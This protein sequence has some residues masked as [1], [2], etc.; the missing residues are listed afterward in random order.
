MA[1][2]LLSSY[3]IQK[4]NQFTKKINII[5]FSLLL[6]ISLIL[7]FIYYT[8]HLYSQ[9]DDASIK[10]QTLESELKSAKNTAPVIAVNAKTDPPGIISLQQSHI[11]I[12]EVL[13]KIALIGHM[14]LLLHESVQGIIT[15]SFDQLPWK[16]ALSVI[17]DL[18]HLSL[19][20]K[21]NILLI[22]SKEN[23]NLHL[24][25]QW[26]EQKKQ[27]S[28]IPLESLLIP[29]HYAKASDI[30]ALLKNGEHAW[31][32]S[33]GSAT[34]DERTNTII[35]LET[36]SRLKSIK[37]MLAR[38]D[39]PIKQVAI[40]A[41]IMN[42]EKNISKEWGLSWAAHANASLESAVSI[43]ALSTQALLDVELQALENENKIEELAHPRLITADQKTAIIRQGE[44]IPYQQSAEY[45]ASTV[46]FKPAVL[47]LQVTPH[48]T[49]DDHILLELVIKN[50]TRGVQS[51]AD[52]I[53]VITTKEIR[54]QVIA[55]NGQTIVLGGIYTQGK[56]E[57]EE[58]LPFLSSL[59]AVGRIFTNTSAQHENKELLVFVTPTILK[60][61]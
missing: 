19:D 5:V 37:T 10:T 32:S 39:V 56:N 28:L 23:E 57:Q 8:R 25:S 17:L 41:R 40:D 59:P 53:P 52:N 45:G 47:E 7:V 14:N 9:L 46:S 60:D 58:R 35:I 51:L 31:L 12:R 50:D 48:I 30:V 22:R 26:Q 2:N 11:D 61:P 15:V 29:L 43:S 42:V 20:K 13:Q 55:K 18:A 38:L 24:E 21:E 33:R 1:F 54:T 27:E 6:F 49:P 34:M 4:K 44:E 16:E 36:P 3:W